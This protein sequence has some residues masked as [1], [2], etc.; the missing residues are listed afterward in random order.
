MLQISAQNSNGGNIVSL[1]FKDTPL[2]T[3]LTE[4]AKQSKKNFV[5]KDKLVK[6]FHVTARLKDFSVS[7]ALNFVLRKSGISFK[8]YDEQTYVLFKSERSRIPAKK[9]I[10]VKESFEIPKSE[11]KWEKAVLLTKSKPDY[12]VAAVADNIEG[13]V[14]IRMLVTKKGRAEQIKIENSSGFP[15]LDSAAVAYSQKLKFIPAK[16]NGEPKD[17]W[18]SMTFRYLFTRNLDSLLNFGR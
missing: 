9:P 16:L 14:G 3:V 15:V 12:P 10:V 1:Q 2:K 18:M 8:E 5:Y 6:D 7:K 11:E 17:V 4:I 13:S